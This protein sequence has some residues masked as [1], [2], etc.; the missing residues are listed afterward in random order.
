MV[1]HFEVSESGLKVLARQRLLEA[2]R[3]MN[4]LLPFTE[5]GWNGQHNREL[6]Q[7]ASTFV[8]GIDMVH[9]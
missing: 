7:S 5:R 9:S 4:L 8:A 3:T 1:M 2:R 6:Q